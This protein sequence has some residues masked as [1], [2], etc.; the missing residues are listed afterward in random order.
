MTNNN[1][2][3]ANDNENETAVTSTTVTPIDPGFDPVVSAIY[4]KHTLSAYLGLTEAQVNWLI[5][6]WS[7]PSVAGVFYGCDIIGAIRDITSGTIKVQP[8]KRGQQ[9]AYPALTPKY[10]MPQSDNAL[11]E[12]L[13]RRA[14]ASPKTF[15]EL[16]QLN[17][18]RPA[19]KVRRSEL[20]VFANPKGL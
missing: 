8:R 15:E 20:V 1:L 11:T 19:D 7:I 10:A 13:T 9:R 16:S 5:H 18:K 17:G 12:P 6:S 2:I 3:H 4:T 14:G